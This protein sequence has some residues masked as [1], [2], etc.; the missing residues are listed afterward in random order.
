MKAVSLLQRAHILLQG[1]IIF[2]SSIVTFDFLLV[3]AQLT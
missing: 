1:Q 2:P 3:M